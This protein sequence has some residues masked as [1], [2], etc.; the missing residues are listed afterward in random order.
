MTGMQRAL[1]TWYAAAV[2]YA[3]VVM[4]CFLNVAVAMT[5]VACTCAETPIHTHML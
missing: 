5:Y 1:T 4:T 2:L 3:V